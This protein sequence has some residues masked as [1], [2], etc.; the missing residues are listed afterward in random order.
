ME[1]RK[2]QPCG[3]SS[4]KTPRILSLD[5]NITTLTSAST[6]Q[7][8]F[9][10]PRCCVG[11]PLTGGFPNTR[12]SPANAHPGEASIYQF[13]GKRIREQL[14]LLIPKVRMRIQTRLRIV[15]RALRHDTKTRTGLGFLSS[16]IPYARRYV[17]SAVV[18]AFKSW[19]MWRT[20]PFR[21]S[22]G[23]RWA[24]VSATRAE[25][26]FWASLYWSST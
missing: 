4:L 6:H 22:R 13:R 25:R 2:R 21:S 17:D 5:F 12:A 9:L 1:H 15:S 10:N 11:F 18:K 24:S 23:R 20:S 3:G 7:H 14:P 19:T 8:V 26:S 16:P